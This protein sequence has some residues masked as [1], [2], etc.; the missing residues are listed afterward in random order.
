MHEEIRNTAPKKQHNSYVEGKAPGEGGCTAKSDK[1]K[2][3]DMETLNTQVKDLLKVDPKNLSIE[4]EVF[5]FHDSS[6]LASQ[7]FSLSIL[8]GQ[9]L[10][11]K[12]FLASLAFTQ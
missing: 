9:P 7:G 3:T 12:A 10:V 8:S 1:Q 2:E 11:I 6:S 5:G 4:R